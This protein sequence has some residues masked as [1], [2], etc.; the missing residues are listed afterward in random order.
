MIRFRQLLQC[1]AQTVLSVSAHQEVPLQLIVQDVLS[2][3]DTSGSPLFQAMFIHERL[4]VQPR[5]SAG[6]TFEPEDSP[7]PG[8]DGRSFAGTDRSSQ[9]RQRTFELPP[10]I[11]GTLHDRAD[12]GSFRD[13]AGGDRR[14]SGS[15]SSANCRC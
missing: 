2:D 15:A 11:V 14:G 5:T 7:A 8:D 1:V 12:G 13:I 6:L 4:P 9:P 3:R 10:R